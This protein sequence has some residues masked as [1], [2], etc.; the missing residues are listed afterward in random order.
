MQDFSASP[1]EMVASFWRNRSLIYA[2]SKREVI[3]RYKGSYL[4]ILWSFFNPLLMLAVYAFVFGEVFNTHWGIKSNSRMEFAIVLFAGLIVFNFFSECVT[5]APSIILLN[6]NYV[7][8]VVFPLE[9]LP[10]VNVFSA[11]FHMAISLL[12]WIVCSLFF[13]DAL[14]FVAILLPITLLPFLFFTLG[15]SWF[16]ASLGVYLRDVSQVISIFVAAL[17]FLSPIFYPLSSLPE[18]YRPIFKLN[19]ITPTVEMARGMLIYGN[20]SNIEYFLVYSFL[21]IIIGWLGFLWFQLTR[22][23]F[24]DVI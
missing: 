21:M 4:G 16:L 22:R 7:K 2:L 18:Q 24:A 3:G 1:R 8:K 15:M 12:V 5:K 23:G 19:P 10:I 13:F 6:I 20:I 14:P 11:I 9:I 17:L